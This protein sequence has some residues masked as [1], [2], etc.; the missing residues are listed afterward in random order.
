MN[1]AD[2]KNLKYKTSVIYPSL[3]GLPFLKQKEI[4]EQTIEDIEQL[5]KNLL[6]KLNALPFRVGGEFTHESGDIYMVCRIDQKYALVCIEGDPDYIGR[7]YAPV[8]DTIE[9]A[10][11]VTGRSAFTPIG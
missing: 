4:I 8:S 1:S 10:F 5:K 7:S 11:G 9:G 2:F 3:T 6:E